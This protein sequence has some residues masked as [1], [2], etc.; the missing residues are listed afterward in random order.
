MPNIPP[1][2]GTVPQCYKVISKCVFTCQKCP[3]STTKLY[4]LNEHVKSEHLQLDDSAHVCTFCSYITDKKTNLKVKIKK[5]IIQI[6][7]IHFYFSVIYIIIMLDNLIHLYFY[8][9]M[10]F[11]QIQIRSSRNLKR[12]FNVCFYLIRFQC[13]LCRRY[14]SNV[15]EFIK[16][17]TE[18]HRMD[19]S[20]FNH[21]NDFP[22]AFFFRLLF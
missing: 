9:M 7:C 19:V 12:L 4:H 3:F 10:H 13:G 16:H 17:I 6:N 2:H 20:I 8:R 14:Q 11:Y 22:N 21:I 1:P 5:N 15:D 18:K